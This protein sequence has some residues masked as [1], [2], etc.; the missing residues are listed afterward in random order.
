V[1]SPR[2]DTGY[3]KE[4]FLGNLTQNVTGDMR[5]SM[6][7]ACGEF[8]QLDEGDDFVLATGETHSVREFVEAAFAC[9]DLDWKEFVKQDPRYQRPAEVDLL[10]GDP[11]KAKKFSVGNQKCRFG[12][13][14]R[15]MVDADMKFFSRKLREDISVRCVSYDRLAERGQ[16][17][18]TSAAKEPHWSRPF[19]FGVGKC[20]VFHLAFSRVTPAVVSYRSESI[21]AS[22]ASNHFAHELRK[23]PVGLQQVFCDF[24]AHPTRRTGSV[25][26]SNEGSCFTFSP[27]EDRQLRRLLRQI[28][29]RLCLPVATTNHRPSRAAALTTSPVR[30]LGPRPQSLRLSKFPGQEH[31]RDSSDPPAA[32]AIFA[33]RN[34]RHGA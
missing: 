12:E 6:S 3:K 16:P 34:F 8:L 32:R 21:A 20:F 33:S 22:S 15:I 28:H 4:L 26:R 19:G 29:V 10:I 5:P 14:V 18:A 30:N 2:L 7:K 13:L 31:R 25:G 1:Q 24:S 23:L 11:S 27:T 17:S 9:A